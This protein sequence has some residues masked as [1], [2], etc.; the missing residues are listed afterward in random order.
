MYMFIITI[1]QMYKK[2]FNYLFV[3]FIFRLPDVTKQNP[4]LC[5]YNFYMPALY[6]KRKFVIKQIV[7]FVHVLLAKRRFVIFFLLLLTKHSY[8]CFIFLQQVSGIII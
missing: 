2:E 6:H 7:F 4:I 5:V 1:L 8:V 3:M